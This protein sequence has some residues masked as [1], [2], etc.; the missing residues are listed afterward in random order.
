[1]HQNNKELPKTLGLTA[2]VI[3]GIGDMLGAGVYGLIGVAAGAMG[4]MVWA[5]FL[6]SAVA[7]LLTALSY[8]SL[9]SRY[10]KA[11]GAAHVAQRAFKLPAVSYVLGLSVMASGLISM[12]AAARAFAAYGAPFVPSVPHFVTAIS[13][14]AFLAFI[15][16]LGMR[17]STWMNALCTAIEL[18]G[19]LFIIAVALPYW[20]EADLTQ[21]PSREDNEAALLILFQGA[22]LTFYAFIGFE[23]LL[24][25]AEEVKDPER[26]FAVGVLTAV[27]I[28]TIVY[29]AVSIS[30]VS[31][32][33]HGELAAAS[34]GPLVLVVERAAPW[35]NSSIFALIA[36]FAIANTALLNYIMASRLAFGM[37]REKL[38]PEFIGRLHGRRKTPHVAITIILV[39]VTVLVQLGDI[40]QLASATSILLI[41]VF[42]V[43][44]VALLVLKRRP[45][46]PKGSFEL[47]SIIPIAAIAINLT[48]LYARLRGSDYLPFY[49][50]GAFLLTISLLYFLSPSRK[51]CNRL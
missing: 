18:S 6:I 46:E 31:V 47:P 30:A 21:I 16:F 14:L 10:P 34:S 50:A 1:M 40:S 33:P 43:M 36:L 25:V 2:L 24:N 11:G 20:G 48:L 38:L 29:M 35:V 23:D 13:F 42:I 45:E 4:S 26:N 17:E 27:L 32:I 41:S 3:Y 9:G 44:N 51:G 28:T 7:A 15:N 49:I 37:S 22:V 19:L 39:I 8:A 5:G 12:A